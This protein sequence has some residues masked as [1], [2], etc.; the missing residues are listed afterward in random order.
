MQVKIKSSFTTSI[1]PLYSGSLS[2]DKFNPSP[3]S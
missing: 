1:Q 2:L 3:V